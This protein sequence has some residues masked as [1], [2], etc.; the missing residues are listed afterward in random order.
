MEH[1]PSIPIIVA[2]RGADTEEIKENT[3][4]AFIRAFEKNADAI[5]GDFHLTKD[6][7][8]VSHHDSSIE[9]RM[10]KTTT[11]DVLQQIQSKLPRL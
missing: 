9:N 1:K 10:I 3:I 4:E 5:E 6:K 11:L 2:H 7:Q 8:I